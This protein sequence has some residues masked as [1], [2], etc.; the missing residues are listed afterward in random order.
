[1]SK[2]LQEVAE[3]CQKEVETSLKKYNCR[4]HAIPEIN[5]DENGN[6][7]MKTEIKIV[8]MIKIVEKLEKPEYIN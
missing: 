1:M 8:P 6:L 5:V 7:K 2:E 4:L 3:K